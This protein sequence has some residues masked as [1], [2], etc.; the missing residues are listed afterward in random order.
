M[1]KKPYSSKIS[2]ILLKHKILE[3]DALQAAEEEART[4]GVRLEKY[5]VEKK[6]VRSDDITLTLSEY[7]KMPP[8]T[9]AHFKPNPQVLEKVPKQILTGRRVM[10]LARVGNN[11][12][13]ALSDP[14]DL[15]AIDELST[16]TGLYITPLVASEKDITDALERC[17]AQQGE[18]FKMDDI[19]KES[20]SDFE[21]DHEKIQED[22]GESIEQMLQGAE[23][24]PV[25]RMVNMMLLEAL[26]TTASDI[27]VEPQEKTLVLRYRIDGSLIESPS[28]PK[29]LQGAILSRLKLM[30]GM[31]IAER[32]VPQDGRIKIRALGREVDLRVNSLPTIWGEKI[33]L[34]I[35][36]RSKLFGSLSALGL[37]EDAYKGMKHG[38]SQPNGIILVTGPTGSG[39]TTTLYSCLQE[40]NTP[41]VNI[42]TCEDPVE[43]Q[44]AGLNQ[45]QINSF[46]G[47]TFSTA[48]R[49]VLRQSPDIILVGEIRDSETADIAIKA[50]LTGHLVLSTLHT[51]DA[52]GAITRLIDMGIEPSLLAA[53][54]ILAQAQ[55]LVSRLCTCKKPVDTLPEKLLE[56]YHIDRKI[57]DGLTV[58]GT[59]AGCPKCHNTGYKGRIAI[60][61]VLPMNRELRNDVIRGAPVK[62]IS[63]KAKANGM[64]GL[65]DV[66]LRKVKEGLTSLEAVLE[67]TGGD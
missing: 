33:V 54:L 32:R 6:L 1:G 45:V 14:F 42:I 50:A 23:G 19:L 40:L 59:G 31:D 39:K 20:D 11:M 21:V 43:Y 60:M 49:E 67:V 64:L 46:V 9:L 25:V 7:L 15:M 57:F 4:T 51:N 13:V 63:A 38:I 52:A 17:F 34:R 65:K 22:S 28:P 58:Y 3:P 55:R 56:T 5:L 44:I 62:E 12:T 41:D 24:A 29:S 36:D 26:R 47:L 66:G 35:L 8:M 53:S 2:D 27:H 61:E 16:A 18:D 37:D 10:P 48:L 30:S